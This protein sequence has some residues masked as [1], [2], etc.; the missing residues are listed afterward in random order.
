MNS[1]R[2]K[3]DLTLFAHP[4]DHPYDSD[5]IEVDKNSKII[6][7]YKKPHKKKYIGN[8]CLSGIYIINKKLIK[9]IKKNKFQDFSKDFFPKII[10]ERKKV[11]A[12]ISREYA[13]DIG[14]PQRFKSG[15]K[16]LIQLNLK[17]EISILKFLQF[18]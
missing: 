15:I 12:Y 17:K 4:N 14:T 8:L 9:K 10:E 7:F 16:D 3:S 2:K 13:K 5:L 11:Y 6:K 18:F 1:I